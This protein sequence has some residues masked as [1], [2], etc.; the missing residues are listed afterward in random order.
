MKKRKVI[1]RN[2]LPIRP[3]LTITLVMYLLLEHFN[4]PGWAWGIVGTILGILWIGGI[5]DIFNEEDIDLLNK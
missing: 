5:L 3:P 2:N 4:A 1:K